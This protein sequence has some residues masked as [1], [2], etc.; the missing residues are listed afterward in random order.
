MAETRQKAALIIV[1]LRVYE[2]KNC[3]SLFPSSHLSSNLPRDRPLFT[4]EP[5]QIVLQQRDSCCAFAFVFAREKGNDSFFFLFF[6]LKPGRVNNEQSPSLL[7][8]PKRI[9]EYFQTFVLIALTEQ[10]PS[11]CVSLSLS[12]PLKRNVTLLRRCNTILAYFCFL[13]LR[14]DT[15]FVINQRIR[16]IQ[17]NKEEGNYPWRDFNNLCHAGGTDNNKEKRCRGSLDGRIVRASKRRSSFSYRASVSPPRPITP[18]ICV[19]WR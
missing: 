1:K 4:M 2:K 18:L 7:G 5:G 19:Q 12:V 6:P 10:M 14:K 17:K 16:E 15:Y 9:S 3:R 13:S 8:R 11:Y